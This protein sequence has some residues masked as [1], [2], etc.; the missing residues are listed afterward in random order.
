M[1]SIIEC[2]ESSVEKLD[3]KNPLFHGFITFLRDHGISQ[4][5]RRIFNDVSMK[6]NCKI[7]NDQMK[8]SKVFFEL[9]EDD[10]E[11]CKKMLAD[12]IS[13]EI[14]EAS[15]RF[16]ISH[17]L[18]DRPSFDMRNQYFPDDIISLSEGEVFIDCGAFLGEAVL[19]I[20]KR[21]NN[22]FK[23]I[24]CFEPDEMSFKR[25][26]NAFN[27]SNVIIY[28]AGVWES[29]TVLHM[30]C[31][32]LSSSKIDTED[33]GGQA[34]QV[35]SIDSLEECADATYIKMDIEGS[36]YSALFGAEKTIRKNRP[37]L[38]ICIY[39]LDEDYIRIIQWINNLNMGYKFFVRHHNC[40]IY[41]TVLYAI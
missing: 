40:S 35:Y 38:A 28:N 30:D 8:A 1:S 33:N 31:T 22:T 26:Q 18:K 7:I 37:K 3:R 39:H 9:H 15:I 20:K 24:V 27:E 29:S 32:G 2:L 34:I 36:E 10:V 17:N 13:R 16:R 11:Q 5:V 19:E 23:R 14:Y 41:D 25:L 21:T 12:D 6:K 4:N